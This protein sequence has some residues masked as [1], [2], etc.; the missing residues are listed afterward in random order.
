MRKNSLLLVILVCLSTLLKAQ[1]GASWVAAYIQDLPGA[2]NPDQLL[3][4]AKEEDI[5]KL[6]GAFFKDT[7]SERRA[8]AYT[9][10]GRVGRSSKKPGV[11]Q[12]AVEK[13]IQGCSDTNS[14]NIGVLWNLLT[15]FKKEN[16]SVG[17]KDSLKNSF[18][19]K[20]AHFSQ[21]LKLMG[22]L[23]MNDMTEEIRPLTLPSNTSKQDRWAALLCLA[24][25]NDPAATQ[26]VV[27]RARKLALNDDVIDE[28]F[29]DLA[30]TRQ[31]EAIDYMV[32]V[33]NSDE[34]KCL[35]ADAENEVSIPCAYRVMEQL[36]PV[37][38]GYPLQLEASGDVKTKDYEKALGSVRTWLKKEPD[39]KIDKKTF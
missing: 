9:I 13:L 26:S 18:R 19:R 28:V 2:G 31:R 37:L 11:K 15:Q 25:M 20:P 16:F 23:E 33:L 5:L 30:Y 38:E 21:L 6:A 39:Y 22:Y 27:Q 1:S 14:G 10:V 35:S 4:E 3:N 36:A 29:P 17:A 12:R 24:R 8:R 34:K 7:L 32:S